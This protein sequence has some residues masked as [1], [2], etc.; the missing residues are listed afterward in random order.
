MAIRGRKTVLAP[1]SPR[2]QAAARDDPAYVLLH[3]VIR[4][5]KRVSSSVAP[6]KNVSAPGMLV[7]PVT[8]RFI[9]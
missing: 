5:A 4:Y 1:G 2:R 6:E 9:A 8:S 7:K 3:R